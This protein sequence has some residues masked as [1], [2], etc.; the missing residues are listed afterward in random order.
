MAVPLLELTRQYQQIQDEVEAAALGVLRSGR[1]IL[2]SEV[3]ALEQEL[4]EYT[5]AKHVVGLSS[6]TDALLAALMALG[7]GPGDRV[8][9]PVY[10]FFATAAEVSRLGARPVFVDI[11]PTWGNMSVEALRRALDADGDIAAVI[12]VHLYGAGQGIEAVAALAAERGIPLVEDTAQAIGT[13]SNGAHAGTTGIC[14]CFST[15]PSKNLGA[16]GDGGFLTT[17]DGEFAEKIRYCR[18]HGQ[19][20]AYR[21]AFVGGNFR[22]DA[23]QAAILRVKLRHLEDWTGKRR[24][25]ASRYREL[26]V[27]V[28]LTLPTD[29][30]R[31]SYH[32]FVIHTEP[33]ARDPLLS[34]LRGRDIGCAVYYPLPFHSQP[35][36]AELGYRDGEF[37]V[38]ERAAATNLALPVFP[39]LRG[40]ELEQ[41]VTEIHAAMDSRESA[42][43]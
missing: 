23:L 29:I 17:N 27:D 13:R 7:I 19:T 30:D 1:Y 5:G 32:Q 4:C 8:A 35:C 31:H 43:S 38:A 33:G 39:E 12:F 16:A 14:G 26:L 11:E 28:P 21:H 36:F 37:P 18:N 34:A 24:H 41:V 9:V 6:G 15:F 42:A 3:E 40:D 20:D 10:S 2:G 22:L 25:N